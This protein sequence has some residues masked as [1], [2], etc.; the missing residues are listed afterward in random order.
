MRK[1]ILTYTICIIMIVALAAGFSGCAVTDGAANTG[2]AFVAEIAE[3]DYAGAYEYIYSFS[4]D[5]Q[6]KDDFVARYENIYE[7]L[8]IDSVRL[9]SRNVEERSESE[10]VLTYTMQ[11]ESA[12]LGT[13]TYNYS[14]EI[15]SGPLGYNVIYTPAL[16][17][18]MLEEGDKIRVSNQSGTRGEIF[19]ADGELL[20]KNDYAQSIYIDLDKEPDFP[21]ILSFLANDYGGDPERLQKKYD[22]AVEKEFPTEV[23]MTFPKGTLS[24]DEKARISEIEGLGVDESRLSPVRYYPLRDTASHMVGYLNSPTDEQL[25]QYKDA[26]I[27]ENSLVGQTGIE[28]EYEETL[29]A[30][31]GRIIYI[32]DS[33]GEMKEVLHEEAKADGADVYLTIDSEL[34]SRAYTLLAANLKEGQSGAVVVMD[35]KTGDVQALC[36]YPSYDNNLFSFPIAPEVWEYY[37]DEANQNPLHFRATQSTYTPGSTFK[38]FAAVP[39]IESGILTEGSTPEVSIERVDNVD[40]WTPNAEGWHYGAITRSEAPVG[41]GGWIFVNAMKSSDNI[42]FAYYTLRYV[43]EYGQEQYLN[44][45]AD[46]GIGEAPEFEL[47]LKASNLYNKD[48]EQNL[49]LP[50]RTGY[51]MAQ[52][53][54]SPL[55]MASMY[56]A[57]E[58]G[59]D[60]VNPTIVDK[61]SRTDENGEQVLY[62]NETTYFKQGIMKQS[63]IDMEKVALRRV[64]KDG[65]AY[66]AKLSGIE[67]IYGKTGTAMLGENNEREVNWIVGINSASDDG[68]VYLV[69]VDSKK[70]EGKLAKLAVLN[71]LMDKSNYNN[72]LNGLAVQ[73]DSASD[74]GANDTGE[75]NSADPGD[76]TDPV[77]DNDPP[78]IIP[79]ED[80]NDPD[81]E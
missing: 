66:H 73:E 12:L 67:S 20:A 80:V 11:L 8:E 18:P 35:Y 46:I 51:G 47:P 42:F 50:V 63:T 27:T 19:S 76:N 68:K 25:E 69:V 44:Y 9:L 24:E 15:I 33:K 74:N 36:S 41:E 30:Q 13:L 3:Q 31:N 57:F 61:I 16:I 17:L 5:I 38:P 59:G 2:Y 6:S 56:T 53:L 7:A 43:Q 26:G 65:T 40:T 28:K 62:E 22:N 23:L 29:R 71:G 81:E 60:I 79:P 1:K 4:P 77:P 78:D 10:Y 39:A 49:D 72:A 55:Q 32:E 64:F 70:N 37:T 14:T 34:Q 58:N 52:L 48:A 21:A 54:V 45:L 75:P